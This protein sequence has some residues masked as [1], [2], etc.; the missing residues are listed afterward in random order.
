MR[1]F[2]P[3][4]PSKHLL[5]K[6]RF[7]AVIMGIVLTLATFY[8]INIARFAIRELRFISRNSLLSYDQK[9]SRY[10]GDNYKLMKLVR[11]N[12]HPTDVITHPPRVSP[13]KY[14][15]VG[16]PSILQYFLYP[17]RLREGYR[18]ILEQDKTITHLLVAEG[19]PKFVVDMRKFHHLP[20]QRRFLLDG[21]WVETGN[22]VEYSELS[23]ELSVNYL[24]SSQKKINEHRLIKRDD[25]SLEYFDL[26]YTLNSY[27]YW[28]KTVDIPLGREIVVKAR[29]RAR[30]H[31]IG[32][33]VEVMYN[34]GKLA[35]FSSAPNKRRYSWDLLTV[36]DL[37]QRA[38]NYGLLKNWDTTN[39][40]ITRIGIDTGVPREMPYLEKYG[41]IELEKGQSR[42]PDE[43]NMGWESAPVLLMSANFYRA[44]GQLKE[45]VRQYQLGKIL[46]PENPW[47]YYGL[48]EIFKEREEYDKAVR[49]YEKTVQLEPTLAWFQFSLGQA[50]QLHKR[51]DLAIISFKKALELDPS[52]GWAKEALDQLSVNEETD[53]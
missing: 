30:R 17:R 22:S 20:T 34:N 14:S 13:W 32:L 46:N 33:I 21:P 15:T 31:S 23:Q 19:W 29:T 38:Q 45:A 1:R 47:F 12:T 44:R 27:D 25:R 10:W 9:M 40:R 4:M 24:S 28:T 36:P 42:K 50:Y 48:G 39:M 43:T 51:D 2:N 35:I 41:L 37:Y 18:R 26:S 52:T 11:D 7:L 53:G 49:E 5:A 16:N 8:T 3:L 6:I